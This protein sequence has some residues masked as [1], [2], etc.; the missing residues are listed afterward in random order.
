[1]IFGAETTILGTI[2][3]TKD[4]DIKITASTHYPPTELTIRYN[5]GAN[6]VQVVSIFGFYNSAYFYVAN[7]NTA[8]QFSSL[9]GNNM[10]VY[11]TP[12]D[13][14]F[15]FSKLLVHSVVFKL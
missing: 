1:M 15:A 4:V 9:A 12:V 14:R 8:I 3:A 7:D 5:G 2:T 13:D 6:V 11:N 10:N